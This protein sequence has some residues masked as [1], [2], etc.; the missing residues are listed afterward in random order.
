MPEKPTLE[1]LPHPEA[2][3][4]ADGDLNPVLPAEVREAMLDVIL[5]WANLDAVTSFLAAAISGMDPDQGADSFGRKV[6][7]DK[8]KS[9]AKPLKAA[10][11]T[12]G[13]ETIERIAVEY[14]DRAYLRK[15]IAHSRCAGVRIS[16]PDAVVFLPFER[17]RPP[18]NLAIEIFDLAKFREATDWARTVHDHFLRIVDGAD[19]FNMEHRTASPS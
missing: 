11:Q 6:I 7:A 13:V 18:G 2:E 10:G 12:E 5:A 9:M 15:R 16:N 1:Y 17:E 3:A 8:L 19:F 4:V 14:S